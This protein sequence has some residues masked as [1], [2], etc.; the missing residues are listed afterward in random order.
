MADYT[1][2]FDLTAPTSTGGNYT[3]ILDFGSDLLE[4]GTSAATA[5]GESLGKGLDFVQDVGEK[6]YEGVQVASSTPV[7][8]MLE[9]IFIPKFITGDITESN[10]SPEAMDVLRKARTTTS[11]VL[12]FLLHSSAVM[13]LMTLLV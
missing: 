4:K 7:R 11:M 5:V 1:K 8:T 10:F 9:D 2:L 13:L 6:A 12:R 3:K